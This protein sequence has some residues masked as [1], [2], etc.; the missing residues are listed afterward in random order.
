MNNKD[1]IILLYI[2]LHSYS[3]TA[4]QLGISRQ[5]VHQV[6]RNYH[7][8]GREKR[9]K[10]YSF[11][12]EI[13]EVCL[14]FPSKHFHHKNGDNTND[15]KENLVSVCIK[16]H[17]K[18]HQDMRENRPNRNC[19]TCGKEYSSSY[20]TNKNL[21]NLCRTY[22]SRKRTYSILRKFELTDKCI[23][24]NE[25]FRKGDNRIKNM[26]RRCF[27]HTPE[28]KEKMKI[29]MRNYLEKKKKMFIHL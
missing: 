6:V 5:R 1:T 7:N 17:Q 15:T 23:T 3:R 18:I 10:L 11:F 8:F 20:K 2:Q 29:Y 16:C 24:C 28:R 4:N 19:Y 12:K 26:C 14:V 22:I 25:R 27:D 21:C 9:L 13:C